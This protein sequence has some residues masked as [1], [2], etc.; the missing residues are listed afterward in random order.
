MAWCTRVCRWLC[1][2]MC[3][4]ATVVHC[5]CSHHGVQVLSGDLVRVTGAPRCAGAP[6]CVGVLVHHGVLSCWCTM[7]SWCLGAAAER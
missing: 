1:T 4:L 2:T 7:L 3:W 6:W 5:R